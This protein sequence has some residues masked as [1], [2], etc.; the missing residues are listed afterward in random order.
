MNVLLLGLVPSPLKQIMKKANCNVLETDK[1]ISVNY[2]RAHSVDFVVSYRYR[3][4]IMRDVLDAMLGSIINL[5]ISFLP[6]NRGADPNLWSF[7]EDSPKG[8]TIH[9]IDEGIDTGDIIAQR[10]VSFDMENETLSTS[11]HKLNENIIDLFSEQ[12]PLIS[13]GKT[14]PQKQSA[15]GTFHRTVDKYRFQYLLGKKGWDTPVKELNGQ[16]LEAKGRRIQRN[17]H[18]NQ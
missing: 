4:I 12:W 13:K 11:Y 5:H 9:Y 15:G 2:L 17:E 16:A 6:W 8:I 3:H 18:N 7:L 10:R 1:T 14:M